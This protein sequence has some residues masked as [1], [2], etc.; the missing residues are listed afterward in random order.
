MSAEG[1]SGHQTNKQLKKGRAMAARP[2][3]AGNEGGWL[4]LACWTGGLGSGFQ[5]PVNG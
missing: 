5:G 1:A 4:G 2:F 3:F